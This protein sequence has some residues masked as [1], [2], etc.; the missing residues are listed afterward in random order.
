MSLNEAKTGFA[1]KGE[2][3]DSFFLLL[4]FQIL[5]SFA[6]PFFSNLLFLGKLACEGICVERISVTGFSSCNTV[7]LLL[8]LYL[9]IFSLKFMR[10]IC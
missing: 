1:N 8:L 3:K 7:L 2:R 6:L 9:F 4:L 10:Q 5:R